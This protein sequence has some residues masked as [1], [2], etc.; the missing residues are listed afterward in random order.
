LNGNSLLQR[1][2]FDK[3]ENG[4]GDDELN[5]CVEHFGL[6]VFVEKLKTFG[7]LYMVNLI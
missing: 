1:S 6:L 7:F 2:I 4:R 3:Q 5:E